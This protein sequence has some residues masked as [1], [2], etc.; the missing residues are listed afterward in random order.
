MAER[1]ADASSS[2]QK[3]NPAL[4]SYKKE[5]KM[6]EILSLKCSQFRFHLP[7]Q[8]EAIFFPGMFLTFSHAVPYKLVQFG[9]L[10]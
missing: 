8:R 4:Q 10:L 7:I 1:N 5:R 3:F 6:V 2:S 9:N